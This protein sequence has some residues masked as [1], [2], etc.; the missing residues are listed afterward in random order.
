MLKYVLKISRDL[1]PCI[2]AIPTEQHQHYLLLYSTSKKKSIKKKSAVYNVAS[3]FLSQDYSS[4]S[5]TMSQKKSVTLHIQMSSKTGLM[6]TAVHGD[7][8]QGY[9]APLDL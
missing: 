4:N 6:K 7:M 3:V 5:L 9:N 1:A 8:L 2:G